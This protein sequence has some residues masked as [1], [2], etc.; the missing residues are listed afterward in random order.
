MEDPVR[1]ANHQFRSRVGACI[2]YRQVVHTSVTQQY[3]LVPAKGRWC[4]AAGKATAGMTDNCQSTT[5][6]MHGFGHLRADCPGSG[7]LCSYRLRDSIPA[8]ILRDHE[9]C[10]P[11]LGNTWRMNDEDLARSSRA[12]FRSS[13]RIIPSF[14]SLT[15]HELA[16][17]L[18]LSSEKSSVCNLSPELF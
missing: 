10:T 5:A 2:D 13:Y 11:L 16:I 1:H 14:I 6:F 4:S 18:F 15:E 17:F 9:Y 3:N 8:E 7:T 12:D